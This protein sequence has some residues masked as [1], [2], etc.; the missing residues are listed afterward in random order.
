MAGELV[1]ASGLDEEPVAEAVEVGE[2]DGFEGFES[3]E[4][5]D[6]SFGASADGACD[7]QT[8]GEFGTAGEDELSE[9][10]ELFGGGV[11]FAFEAG[12]P[13]G[14]DGGSGGGVLA[15]GGCSEDGAEC[16]EFVLHG[17]Q[18]R[19]KFAGL[20]RQ[21]DCGESEVGV[22]FV[23]GSVGVDAE[24]VFADALSADESGG[25]VVAG[26]GVEVHGLGDGRGDGEGGGRGLR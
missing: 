10:G 6:E 9:G 4:G 14:S 16:E 7:V 18:F 21:S 26:A 3:V 13:F 22:E 17:L 5:D 12:G 20:P 8:S 15:A 23:D 1:G 19:C 11:D 24:V 2:E 25:A